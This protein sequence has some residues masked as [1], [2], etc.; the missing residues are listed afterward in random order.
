VLF[1]F[2]SS[3]SS[4]SV[5]SFTAPP[6]AHHLQELLDAVTALDIVAARANHAAWLGAVRPAFLPSS[7][8]SSSSP[9]YM[10]GARHPLL[11]QVALPPLPRPPS[12]DDASFESDFV[13]PPLW[14]SVSGGSS[15]SSDS[16]GEAGMGSNGNGGAQGSRPM[17]KPLDLRVPGDVKVVAITGPNTGG[18]TVTLKTAGLMAL[19]AK[20][21]M[22]IPVDQQELA[23]AA[24]AAPAA[25]GSSSS[26]SSSSGQPHL[27]WFDQ[28]LADIGDA[29]S[30][31][32]NLSTFSG[33][34][35]RL[36]LLLAGAGPGSLVLLDEVGSGTD[37]QV[38]RC[39]SS[40]VVTR[41][42]V[43]WS[44]I[45]YASWLAL[46]RAVWCCW[47][48]WEAAQTH[49]YAGVVSRAVVTRGSVFWSVM[50]HA[51]WLV[52]GQAVWC[53][54]MKW[55]AA[56]I[57]RYACVEVVLVTRGSVFWSLMF[58]ASWLVQGQEVWCCWMK[59]EVARTLRYVRLALLCWG[60]VVVHRGCISYC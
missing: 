37:P 59:W 50:F 29:Q 13:P 32:Q 4:N 30:L 15:S 47:M 57:L 42:S 49:R 27:L 43:F 21:G 46:G 12:V 33:H 55:A 24:A 54:W 16:D 51:S 35:A 28:V 34:I 52:Q 38:C 39:R 7:S 11:M 18:K 44:A 5:I 31:Q 40:A 19:M 48:K 14:A 2:S 10:P 3:T 26:S 20:A 25:G 45:F 56:Q 58:H 60:S 41:G 9:V 36:K 53:F 17:P 8:G 23:A 1:S 6:T 22:F